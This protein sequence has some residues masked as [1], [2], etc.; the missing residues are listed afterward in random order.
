MTTEEKLAFVFRDPALPERPD[1]SEF[2]SLY[3]I[4]RDAKWLLSNGHLGES[5]SRVSSS[6]LLGVSLLC[7]GVDLLAKY[8]TGFFDKTDG[9][10]DRFIKFITNCRQPSNAVTNDGELWWKLRNALSH[11]YGLVDRTNR[12]EQKTHVF[13]LDENLESSVLTFV[14]HNNVLF[15]KPSRLLK[16]FESLLSNYRIRLKN[17]LDLKNNLLKAFDGLG[18][19]SIKMYSVQNGQRNSNVGSITITYP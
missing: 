19:P 10:R 11:S 3:L 13:Q 5:N 7:T 2:S 6:K 4:R 15:V 18:G 1:E 8:E 12:G 16:D 9:V 17:D 14:E